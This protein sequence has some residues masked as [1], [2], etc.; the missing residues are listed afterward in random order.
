MQAWFVSYLS[1][2]RQYT[3]V[4]N[5]SSS[6]AAISCGVPQGSVLGPLLFLIYINDLSDVV[7]RNQLK[8]FADDL[9]LF[10]FHPDLQ[11]LEKNANDCLMAMN[12]WFLSNR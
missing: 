1:N 11:I 9:N 12:C 2:R 6:E 8:M 7:S 4:N 3:C 5:V 10:M